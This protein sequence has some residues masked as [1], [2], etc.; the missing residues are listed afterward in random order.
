MPRAFRAASHHYYNATLANRGCDTQAHIGR[1]AAGLIQIHVFGRI[2]LRDHDIVLLRHRHLVHRA[3][4]GHQ[5]LVHRAGIT[6]LH[7]DRPPLAVEHYV[8]DKPQPDRLCGVSHELLKW[9]SG[10]LSQAHPGLIQKLR[11]VRQP[12]H[13]FTP[14]ADHRR[15]AAAGITRVW[16]WFDYAR[17]DNEITVEEQ[18]IH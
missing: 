17:G 13:F 14:A 15:F 2:D 5:R 6:G 4:H 16:M 8:N 18:P 1:R 11:P 12:E 9:I 3:S 10:D 7:G